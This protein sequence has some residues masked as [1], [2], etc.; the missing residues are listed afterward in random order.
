MEFETRPDK[1][2]IAISGFTIIFLFILLMIIISQPIPDIVKNLIVILFVSIIGITYILAPRK[3]ILNSD[4]IKIK[5]IIGT[6]KIPV[7]NIL[8]VISL[9]QS[10]GFNNLSMSW[11]LI[12]SGGLFGYYGYYFSKKYGLLNSFL[13]SNE[14]ILLI[15][16]KSKKFIISPYPID[17][18]LHLIN[19]YNSAIEIE[20]NE[21][22]GR[23]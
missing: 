3:I 13:T 1:T 4:Y 14:R 10:S 22:Y 7:D 18:F 23:Y 12:G 6:V 8:K 2:V 17:E 11:R 21:N 19:S 9:P 15:L 20:S 16:T 5:R